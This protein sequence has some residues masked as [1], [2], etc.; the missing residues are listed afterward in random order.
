MVYGRFESKS[1]LMANL[2]HRLTVS[3]NKYIDFHKVEIAFRLCRDYVSIFTTM[4]FVE[5]K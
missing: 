2:K 3:S 5:R 1:Y 4:L